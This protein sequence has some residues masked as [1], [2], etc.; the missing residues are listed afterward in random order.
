MTVMDERTLEPS[1]PQTLPETDEQL[2]ERL[3]AKADLDHKCCGRHC[4][5]VACTGEAG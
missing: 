1:E 4:S 2:I 5:S 3:L